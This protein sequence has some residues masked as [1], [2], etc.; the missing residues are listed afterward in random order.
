MYRVFNMGI[1]MAV[2]CSPASVSL[3][4]QSLPE[5][6]V[7]GEVVKQGSGERVVID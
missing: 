7:I 6:R 3:F 4:T 1:G 5:S 2:F